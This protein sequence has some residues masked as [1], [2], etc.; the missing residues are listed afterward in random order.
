MAKI[1]RT[2]KWDT[3]IHALFPF[4]KGM[5]ICS[6][7]VKLNENTSIKDFH[8]CCPHG[9]CRKEESEKIKPKRKNNM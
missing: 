2:A 9:K 1:K 7:G 8:E 5:P 4:G 6:Y 3:C